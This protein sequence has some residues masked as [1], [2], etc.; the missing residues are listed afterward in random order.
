MGDC[1]DAH[2]IAAK[3]RAIDHKHQLKEKPQMGRYTLL[4]ITSEGSRPAGAFDAP[5]L[6]EACAIHIN[7]WHRR[8][9]C[10][11]VVLVAPCGARYSYDASALEVGK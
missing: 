5:T 4:T 2:R 6:Q 3:L 9:S 11:A 7:A 10:H 8:P 1:T